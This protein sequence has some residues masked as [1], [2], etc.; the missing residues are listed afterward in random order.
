MLLAA[1]PFKVNDR[2]ALITWQYGKFPPSLSHGWLEPAYTGVVKGITLTYTMIVTDSNAV[3]K[4]PNSIVTQ[5]LIMNLS[6]GRQGI[7]STQF[8]VPIRIEPELLRNNLKSYLAK[9]KEFK[10]EEIGF[11]ILDVSPV[12][13]LVATSYNVPRQ[14]EAEMKT[15]LLTAIRA[16][17]ASLSDK[18][19]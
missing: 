4:V 1:R 16:A 15:L 18:T 14:T 10:G 2:I 7:A 12:A 13:Y 8:E 19:S 5:S 9:I 6:P 17:L 11:E 3:L